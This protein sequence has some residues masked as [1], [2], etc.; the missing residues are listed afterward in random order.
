MSAT[1]ASCPRSAPAASTRPSAKQLGAIELTENRRQHEP[2]ERQALARLRRGDPEPYLTYA[3]KHGRLQVDDDPTAAKQRLLEDWWQSSALDPA[4]SVMIA[5]RRTDIRDLNQAAHALMLRADRLGPD[6]L[7]LGEREFRVGDRV[8]CRQ[9]DP[10]LGLRNGTRATITDLDQTT[11]TLRTDQGALR[12]TPVAYAAKHLDHGYALTGHAAQ[13]ATVDRAFVLVEDRGALQ[14][15]GYVACSRARRETRL[16]LATPPLDPDLPGRR[17]ATR[18]GPGASRP[19]VDRQRLRTA[20]DRPGRPR[21]THNRAH[22]RNAPTPARATTSPN[23]TATRRRR[24]EARP[25]RM[26]RPSQT[27][28]QAPRRD[29]LPTLG[30]PTRRREAC[31]NAVS[32]ESLPAASPPSSTHKRSRELEQRRE[33]IEKVRQRA[34]KRERDFG[35]EW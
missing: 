31:P 30:A 5:Y 25:A 23:R 28:R 17:P 16:Y 22:P 10:R 27:R 26:A 8:L 9:N 15:W 3:A 32:C 4:G 11:L 19:R 34:P 29:R 33:P 12:R 6:A 14:E 21:S 35:L 18:P 20:R 7:L 24:S 1:R 13:G 2:S